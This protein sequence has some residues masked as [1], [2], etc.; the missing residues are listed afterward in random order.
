M[1]RMV[2]GFDIFGVFHRLEKGA[3]NG[4]KRHI[5]QK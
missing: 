4:K 2:Q 1:T 5:L 3:Y